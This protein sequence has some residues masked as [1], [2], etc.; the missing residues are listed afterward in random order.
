MKYKYLCHVDKYKQAH[1]KLLH[2]G[3]HWSTKHIIGE[4][5]KTRAHDMK[6]TLDET[7]YDDALKSTE[8]MRNNEIIKGNY[9]K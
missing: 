9:N 7:G 6:G 2:L 4:D 8:T 5:S 1:Q 3:G